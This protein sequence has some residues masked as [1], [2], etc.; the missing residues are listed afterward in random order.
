MAV[1]LGHVHNLL[2]RSTL[3]STL[4]LCLVGRVSVS[5]G[6]ITVLWQEDLESTQL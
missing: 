1:L 4:V 5:A 6:E 2:T 3:A